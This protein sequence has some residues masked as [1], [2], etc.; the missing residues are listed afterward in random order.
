MSNPYIISDVL[1]GTAPQL[2][3]SYGRKDLSTFYLDFS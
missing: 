3:E 1:K 2:L